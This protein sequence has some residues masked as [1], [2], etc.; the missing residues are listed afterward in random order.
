[1]S[2]VSTYRNPYHLCSKQAT[3]EPDNRNPLQEARSTVISQTPTVVDESQ[4]ANSGMADMMKM[5]IEMQEQRDW[6]QQ[7]DRDQQDKK[8]QMHFSLLEDSRQERQDREKREMRE[9][10]DCERKERE[11]KEEWQRQEEKWLEKLCQQDIL[12]E[13]GRE[14]QRMTSDIQPM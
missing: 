14:Y 3:S 5:L 2:S 11:Q 7:E 12:R 4:M 13:Q 9:K 10:E 8:D 1:M 6:V